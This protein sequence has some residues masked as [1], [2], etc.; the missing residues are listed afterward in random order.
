MERE[1][2]VKNKSLGGL[3]FG[4]GELEFFNVDYSAISESFFVLFGALYE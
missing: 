4:I 1:R 2:N 3:L